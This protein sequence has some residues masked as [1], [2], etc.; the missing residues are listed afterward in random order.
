MSLQVLQTAYSC[1]KMCSVVHVKG[2]K[3]TCLGFCPFLKY[4]ISLHAE[5]RPLPK[6]DKSIIDLYKGY[7]MCL[8]GTLLWF[9]ML[10]VYLAINWEVIE[11]LCVLRVGEYLSKYTAGKMPKAFKHIPATLMWEEVLYLTEPEKWSPNA[12]FQATRI[13][14]SNLGSKKAERFYRLVLLPRVREDIRKNKRLHFALY[15]SLKKSLYK[16]AAF[17]KGILFP[18]CEVCT[19]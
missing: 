19:S 4:G 18:L 5:V 10:E 11:N 13:F 3:K 17:N 12:M 1:S 2:K 8:T 6:L 7:V 15:Q 14:S 16:P 9:C